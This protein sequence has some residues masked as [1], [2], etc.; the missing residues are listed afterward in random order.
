MARKLTY[1]VVTALLVVALGCTFEPKAYAYVDPGS[2]LLMFQGI[3][4][5]VTGTLIYFRRKL[6]AL[7]IKSAKEETEVPDTH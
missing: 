7:F 6:K 5:A 2:G 4:A 3:S 1:L